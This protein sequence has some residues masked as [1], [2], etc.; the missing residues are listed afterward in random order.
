MT[1]RSSWIPA[2]LLM[3]LL[4]AAAFAADV[5]GKW[6]GQ[7]NS[8]G[9]DMTI[10]FNFKQTGDKL[11]GTVTGPGGDLEIQDGKVSGDKITFTI[12]FNDMKIQHEG[13]LKGDE[14]SLSMKMDG[15]EAPGPMILK[16][17]K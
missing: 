6:T 12:S 3:A 11:T 16:R 17:A 9:G 2:A 15:G 4:A 10:T 14:I 1:M 13:A 5:T 7:F 8:P